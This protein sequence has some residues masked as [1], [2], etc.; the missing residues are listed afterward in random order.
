MTLLAFL[1]FISTVLGGW[2]ALRLRHRLHPVMAFAAG[3]LVTT[4][5]VN[6]L[7]EGID[8]LGGDALLAGVGTVV[9]YLL[10]SAVEAFVHREA[11]EHQ[12]PAG[13]DPE[14]PHDHAG[15]ATRPRSAVG[16]VGPIGLIVHSTLDGIAIGLAFQA[17][18]QIGVIVTL[19][20]LAHDFADG[21]N[22]VTLVVSGGGG[23]GWAI[24]LL[25]IDAIAPVAGYFVSGRIAVAPAQLGL[26]LS[27]FAGVFLAIGA[28]HL[29]P[30]A[31]HRRPGHA[32]SLVVLALIGAILVVAIRSV[33]A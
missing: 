32:V 25:V 33:L 8:L 20:V 2:A 28:G 6:L 26:L 5:L 29:L 24:A 12:H 23:R 15:A 19:A 18:G 30:E 27:V 3:V 22:V 21:L 10:F 9:G 11:Y 1:P 13:V 31:Q 14:E 17:G 7:P 4:A 16:F